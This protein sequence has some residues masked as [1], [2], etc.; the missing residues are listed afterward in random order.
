MVAIFGFTREKVI[1]AVQDMYTAVATTPERPFHFPVG[2]EACLKV[3]YPEASLEGL[4]EEG[5]RSFAGVACPFR[6]GAIREGDTVLDIGA[7]AGTDTLIASRLVGSQGKVFALDITPAMVRKLRELAARHGIGNV[8]VIEGNAEAI[9]LPDASV[10]VVTSNG[11]LNLV[12]DKRRAIAEI[13]RVLRPGGRVQIADIVIR[14]PVTRDCATDPKLWAECVVG[15][16]VDDDYLDMFRDAGFDAVTVHRGYDYFALSPSGETRDVARRFGARAIEI[17]MRRAG[18]AP[19]KLTQ[20]ARRADPRRTLRS[21]ARRGLVGSAA[22]TLSVF[23][24]YGVLAATALLALAGITLAINPAVWAGTIVTLGA[25]AAAAVAAGVR[26]HGSYGALG[27]ALAGVAALAYVQFVDYSM[28]FELVAFG[29]LAGG[30][31]LDY[32]R[33]RQ[34]AV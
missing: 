21:L 24:C 33:R 23:A 27:F 29:L 28:G 32:L 4:P 15:A 2:R 10:D 8:E 22:L 26:R 25:L 13:F 31:A 5:L 16:T 3:G 6:A 34:S 19:S 14:R 12:P 20:L 30:V 7:G 18:D 1:A 11:M 9:P 17:S